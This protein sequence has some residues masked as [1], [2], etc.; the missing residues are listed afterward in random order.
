M[1][2]KAEKS[3]YCILSHLLVSLTY[4]LST[5]DPFGTISQIQKSSGAVI[6]K[7]VEELVK[8]MPIV[9]HPPLPHLLTGD[10][11]S[12]GRSTQ[13]LH[14]FVLS[15]WDGLSEVRLSGVNQ[16]HCWSFPS[17]QFFLYNP[18]IL[19]LFLLF[20]NARKVLANPIQ[21]GSSLHVGSSYYWDTLLFLFFSYTLS[22]LKDW[23]FLLETS[24]VAFSHWLS[25]SQKLVFSNSSLVR[26]REFIPTSPLP[27][28]FCLARAWTHVSCACWHNGCEFIVQLSCFIK[29]T[30]LSFKS[31][32]TSGSYNRSAPPPYLQ[33]FSSF[34]GKHRIQLFHLELTLHGLLFSAPWPVE[35]ICVIHHLLRKEAYLI[36]TKVCINLYVS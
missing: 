26:G 7:A 15:P 24:L 32:I 6:P 10:W 19:L 36:R 5:C 8:L 23:Y 3:C 25:H 16:G 30:L 33:W 34:G 22:V 13:C 9:K 11:G 29:K 4:P 20:L 12:W 35:G 18:T 1:F 28:R 2:S 31:P 27:G 14:G 21:S 17:F